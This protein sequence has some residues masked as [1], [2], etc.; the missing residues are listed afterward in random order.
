MT[1]P[2][3]YPLCWPPSVKRSDS[4]ETSRFNTTWGKARAKV[5]NSLR[6]F[7][8]DSGKRLDDIVISTNYLGSARP[9]DPGVAVYFTWDNIPICI[10]VDRY[11]TPWENL[12]AIF[13]V[14]EARRTELRHGTLELVRASLR[15]FH[16][17]PP[18]GD[19]PWRD[20]LGIKGPATRELVLDVYRRLAIERHPDRGGSDRMMAELNAARDA[21]LREVA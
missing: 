9:D 6:L 4:R 15:G 7:A 1:A 16:A 20:V 17:L 19:R 3:A 5:R 18:P 10:A 21:A 2:D 14:I 12:T 8:G 11:K 13:H